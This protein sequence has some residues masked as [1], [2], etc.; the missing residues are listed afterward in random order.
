LHHVQDG[1]IWKADVTVNYT[2]CIMDQNWHQ[3]WAARSRW[4][5]HVQCIAEQQMPKRLLY[6]KISWKRKVGRP[7]SR[8]SDEVH[9]DA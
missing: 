9:G 4:V 6:A 1:G 7:K 8:R 2:H 3:L 5:S